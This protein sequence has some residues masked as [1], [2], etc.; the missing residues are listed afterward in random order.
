MKLQPHTRFSARDGAMLDL[1]ALDELSVTPARWLDAWLAVRAP[2]LQGIVLEGLELDAPLARGGPPGARTPARGSSRVRVTPGR[3]L[4]ADQEGRHQLL[5]ID[6]LNEPEWS[7]PK[8]GPAS[9]GV[10]ALQLHTR[11]SASGGLQVARDDLRVELG[12]VEQIPDQ[13]HLVP[14]AASVGN[15]QDWATDLARV[16]QPEHEAVVYLLSRFRELETLVW[17]AQPDG[18]VWD[19]QVL[20]RNWVRYQTVAASALQAARMQLATRAFTTT[21]RVRLLTE[22]RIQLHGSVE[23]AANL[24]VQLMGP[25]DAAGPYRAVLNAIPTA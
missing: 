19:R 9:P 10:L 16:W 8:A 24:L 21:E 20:G 4:I 3:V 1:T 7:R 2:K 17:N 6:E 13:V 11:P 18:S 25:P 14:L 22:L 15:G 5:E 12:F 23:S